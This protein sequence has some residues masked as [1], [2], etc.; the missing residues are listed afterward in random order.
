MTRI[1]PAVLGLAIATENEDGISEMLT[2]GT[3]PDSVEHDGR[4][5]EVLV[6][7]AQ[8]AALGTA[9]SVRIL[10]AIANVATASQQAV[11]LI[12][13]ASEDSTLL[14]LQALLSAGIAVDALD[15]KGNTALMRAAG[16]GN[17]RNTYALLLA[18]ADSTLEGPYGSAKECAS[19]CEEDL[20]NSALSG[21]LRCPRELL[22]DDATLEKQLRGWLSGV[23]ALATQHPQE[24]FY[25]FAID[26]GQLRGNGEV[27]FAKTLARYQADFGAKY[28][29]PE[30]IATLKYSP[31]DWSY[32]AKVSSNEETAASALELDLTALSLREND[33]RTYKM[34]MTELLEGNRH[35]FETALRVSPDFRLRRVAHAY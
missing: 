23:L 32:V 21:S 34:L 9:A 29:A 31:G 14:E 20:I 16:N 27:A 12:S 26:G 28:E 19:G 17:T 13:C 10:R 3:V 1:S 24:V 35:V 30:K 18:G 15:S 2:S 22:E 5:F 11:A 4:G 8:R 25:A 6:F 33:D 7:A